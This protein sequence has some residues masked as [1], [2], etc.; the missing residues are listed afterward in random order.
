MA[1]DPDFDDEAEEYIRYGTPLHEEEESRT[2]QRQKVVTDPAATK[3]LP[4]WQQ[5]RGRAARRELLLSCRGW[6]ML[7]LS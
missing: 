1:G 4:V 2:G 5:V 3:R 6:L 7:A